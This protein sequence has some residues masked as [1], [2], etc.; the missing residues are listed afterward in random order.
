MLERFEKLNS[1][2]S[3]WLE[4]LGLVAIL[5]LIL[6]TCVDVIGAKVFLKPVFGAIDIVKLA[7]LIAI[8]FAVAATLLVGRHVQVEFFVILLP[9]KIQ[10]LVD[11]FVQLLGFALFVVIVWRMTV[12]AYLMQVSGEVSSTARIPLF[13]FAYGVAVSFVPVC[14]IYLHDFLKSI[15]VVGGK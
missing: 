2:L 1:R 13:Y 15:R 11:A 6:I 14:L 10:A 3:R 12:Y 8:A 9:K 4:W 7:Q 5:L